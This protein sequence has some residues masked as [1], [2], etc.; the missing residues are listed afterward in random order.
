[1]DKQGKPQP[2]PGKLDRAAASAPPAKPAKGAGGPPPDPPFRGRN[3]GVATG[4]PSEDDR[5]GKHHHDG[6][7]SNT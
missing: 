5:A 7:N 2:A 4:R 3:E 6:W 1:M